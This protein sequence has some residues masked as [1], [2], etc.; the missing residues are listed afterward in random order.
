MQVSVIPPS[1]LIP[2]RYNLYFNISSGPPSNITCTILRNNIT[3]VI[4]DD[5]I[6][7]ETSDFEFMGQESDLSKVMVKMSGRI[8]GRVVCSVSV[9][10]LDN[11]NLKTRTNTSSVNLNGNLKL[12]PLLLNF[13]L[14]NSHRNSS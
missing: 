5:Q 3:E 8:T 14:L 11:G 4:P 6:V 13:S 10:L 9:I 12:L 1:Y 2:L 7:V